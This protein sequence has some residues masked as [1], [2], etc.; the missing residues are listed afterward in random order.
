MSTAGIWLNSKPEVKFQYD[1][2]SGEFNG[3]SSQSYVSHCRVLP[4]DK[5]NG[6]SFQSHVLLWRVGLLTV[7]EFTV[8]VQSTAT[9]RIAW[10]K[11]SI[12]HIQNRFSPYFFVL[13]QFRFDELRLS[14]RLRY[15]CVDSNL[16]V[17]STASYIY[18]L[19]NVLLC[20]FYARCI[21]VVGLG[22]HVADTKP[23]TSGAGKPSACYP[24][25]RC[26]NRLCNK[27]VVTRTVRAT[28]A[29]LH[30]RF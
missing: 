19:L 13:M 25:V 24:S 23:L 2:S 12:R 16:L 3:V 22:L 15:S 26:H 1:G 8:I 18:A 4:P 28:E 20:L 14:Y 30:C 29:R 6:M 7:G 21:S 27:E 9:C 10:C 17:W 5:F 11:N